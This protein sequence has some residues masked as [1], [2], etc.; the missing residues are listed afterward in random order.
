MTND[1]LI[2][3]VATEIKRNHHQGTM[4]EALDAAKAV[5]PLVLRL[6][7]K[8]DE[9]NA[10]TLDVI[11]RLA[12]PGK[13][14][15]LHRLAGYLAEIDLLQKSIETGEDYTLLSTEPQIVTEIIEPETNNAPTTEET[16]TP[17]AKARQ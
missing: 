17:G 4:E 12:D 9:I 14:S 8:A 15:G 3:Q 1:D 2:R 7:D 5:I 6:Q 11:A 13:E 10:M 16:E